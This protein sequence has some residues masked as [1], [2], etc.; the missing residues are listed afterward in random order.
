MIGAALLGAVCLLVPGILAMLALWALLRRLFSGAGVGGLVIG[1]G[2]REPDLTDLEERQLV[3]VV[4]EM[5]IAAGLPAPR[6]MLLDGQIA[7]AAVVGSAPEDAVVV[8]SRRLLDEM[9]RDETQ[10]ILAHQIASIGNGDLGD[11]ALDGDGVPD[12]RAGQHAAGRADQLVGPAD[13]L[14]PV[15]RA[16]RHGRARR[17]VCGRPRRP[18]CSARASR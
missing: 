16:E 8:V 10:G 6:V 13:A 15:G 18:G 1:L 17:G 9:D 7:N 4:E 5:A 12:L 14:A 3:N 11:R 2:A